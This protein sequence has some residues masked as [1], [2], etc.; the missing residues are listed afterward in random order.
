MAEVKWRKNTQPTVLISTGIDLTGATLQI[1]FKKPGGSTLSVT[2]VD[3]VDDNG[4]PTAGQIR[5]E[6]GAA[7]LD[8][9]GQWQ[10]VALVT[11]SSKPYKNVPAATFTVVD[12]FDT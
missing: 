1:D 7:E 12:D 10:A 3:G 5:Y 11:I 6:F 8:E 4:A 9:T 2:S